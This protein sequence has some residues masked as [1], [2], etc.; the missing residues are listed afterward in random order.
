MNGSQKKA[1][2][3]KNVVRSIKRPRRKC[4]NPARRDNMFSPTIIETPSSS[5][6]QVYATASCSSYQCDSSNAF[7]LDIFGDKLQMDICALISFKKKLGDINIESLL[8]D[9]HSAPLEI[10][11]LTCIDKL[12]VFSIDEILQM[13][14]LIDGTFAMLHL[15]SILHQSIHRPSLV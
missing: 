3:S 9:S 6:K 15:N 2:Y 1:V 13:R 10:V 7:Y 4:A 11:N 12:F 5:W 14:D 8:L